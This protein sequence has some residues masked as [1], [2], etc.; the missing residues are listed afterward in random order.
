MGVGPFCLSRYEHK[1][2]AMSLLSPG[3]FEQGRGHMMFQLVMKLACYLEPPLLLL[4]VA[5]Q[6]M[7][8]QDQAKLALSRCFQS[9][10]AHPMIQ[11][12]QQRQVAEEVERYLTGEDLRVLPELQAFLASLRF[13]YG[14]ERLVE[15]GHAKVHLMHATRCNRTEYMDSLALRFHEVEEVLNSTHVT[16]LLECLQSARTP[17]NLVGQLGLLKHPGVQGAMHGWD[18]VYIAE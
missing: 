2:E 13:C 1:V 5:D 6:R 7:C 4:G 3:D 11:Q 14:C 17:R 18:A 12:L 9:T 10:C 16:S 15:G 8:R